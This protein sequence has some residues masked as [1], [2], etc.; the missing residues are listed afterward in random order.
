MK[1]FSF[2]LASSLLLA[3]CQSKPSSTEAAPDP[4]P[5]NPVQPPAD[6][7]SPSGIVTTPSG[8]RYRVLASGPAEGRSPFRT[9]FV[10]VHYH[11]TLTDGTVFDSSIDRGT[12]ASFGVG[13]V[14]P[15]WT[16]ALQCMKPGDKWML[17]I[18]SRLAYGP[19]AVGGKIPPNSDLIFEVELL[20]IL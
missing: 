18:P 4:A 6:S 10:T 8:L 17:F 3:S 2:L 12:P 7:V 19:R 14:I 9:D 5:A 15:G 11:G 20:Q 13:Q 1:P 16:E